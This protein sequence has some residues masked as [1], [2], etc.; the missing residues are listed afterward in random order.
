MQDQTFYTT[1]HTALNDCVKIIDSLH[2]HTNFNSQRISLLTELKNNLHY[3]LGKSAYL[4]PFIK[5]I[6]I[7]KSLTQVELVTVEPII[8]IQPIVEVELITEAKSEVVA[9]INLDITDV[10][11]ITDV[12]AITDIKVEPITDLEVESDVEADTESASDS[13]IDITVDLDAQQNIITTL[14]EKLLQI[15][16]NLDDKLQDLLLQEQ[17]V[18][19]SLDAA[20][21]INKTIVKKYSLTDNNDETDAYINLAESRELKIQSTLQA[22]RDEIMV[23]RIYLNIAHQKTSAVQM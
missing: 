10:E 4:L 8:Y 23:T 15:E 7:V 18:V 3:N 12:V 17:T 5:V 2:T 6:P 13:N 11:L 14:V 16:Y 9:D 1:V 19:M 20:V 21:E 22:I